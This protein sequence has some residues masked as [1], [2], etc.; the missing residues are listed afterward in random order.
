MLKQ[1]GAT[2]TGKVVQGVQEVDIY[3][4]KVEGATVSFKAQPPTKDR[5]ITFVGKVTS[6]EIIFTRTFEIKEGGAAGGNALLGGPTGPPEF[7]AI[8]TAP[9]KDV[10][11]GTVRNAPNPNNPGVPPPPPRPVTVA[12]R[13]LPDPHWRW[14]G[15]GKTIETRVFNQGNQPTPVASFALEGDQLTFDYT[16]G[17]QAARWVCMLA[18]QADGQFSGGCRPEGGNNPGLLITLT[19]PKEGAK[20][21]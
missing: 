10:W 6:D 5:V 7:K 17:P 20:R 14:R 12:M 16:Q 9:D 13:Q 4:A 1:E 11:S 15:D 2:I 3:E 19:P 21:P 8:R 18:R